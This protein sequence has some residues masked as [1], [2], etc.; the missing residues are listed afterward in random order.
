MDNAIKTP[1]SKCSAERSVLLICST[2]RP[3]QK[4]VLCPGEGV[5][6]DFALACKHIDVCL[7]PHIDSLKELLHG[8]GAIRGRVHQ[9]F[10][11]IYTVALD[12]QP[13]TDS[14]AKGSTCS[15]ASHEKHSSWMETAVDDA[16]D[17]EGF[18]GSRT[19]HR[20]MGDVVRRW[21]PCEGQR[22]VGGSV[23][24]SWLWSADGLAVRLS[25]A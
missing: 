18:D 10:C 23:T 3:C 9:I 14:P 5:P 16:P 1:T 21:W 4:V 17:P 22:S 25:V 19:G 11:N 13:Q 24:G 15:E 7:C 6:A 2:R 20:T 8:I 12:A